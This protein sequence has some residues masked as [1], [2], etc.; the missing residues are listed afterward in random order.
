MWSLR[1]ALRGHVPRR[2]RGLGRRAHRA[3]CAGRVSLSC[4]DSIFLVTPTWLETRAGHD[5][6]PEVT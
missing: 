4:G 1:A 6:G 2:A 3:V 5:P